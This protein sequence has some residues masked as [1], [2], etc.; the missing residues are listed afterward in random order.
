M[1]E[2]TV[3]ATQARMQNP[4]IL[5][6]I[7]PLI[8]FGAAVVLFRMSVDDVTATYK[9][10]EIFVPTVAVLSLFSGWHQCQMMGNDRVWYVLRQF[11]HWGAIIAVL[12]LFHIAG[13][14]E[15]LDDRQYTVILLGILAVATLLEAIQMD[16]K[17]IL[18]S[19]FLAFCAYVLYLPEGNAGLMML[20]NLFGIEDPGSHPVTVVGILA[21]IGF[22]LSLGVHWL[23]PSRGRSTRKAAAPESSAATAQSRGAPVSP[24]QPSSA[25]R[26]AAPAG[27]A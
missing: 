18:F 21:V 7:P 17:L 19:L 12:Y 1:S 25:S 14:R 23:I 26:P 27:T 16:Y 22:V 5:S 3:S 8:L 9:Y 20:G 6:V 24:A 10:W 2:V 4:L 13:F 15:L 11:I